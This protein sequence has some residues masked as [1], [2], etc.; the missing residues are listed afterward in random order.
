MAETAKFD[1]L[2]SVLVRNRDFALRKIEDEGI[3]IPIRVNFAEDNR[4]YNLNPLAV[5]FWELVDGRRTGTEIR[6]LLAEEYDVGIER[7]TEDLETFV[8]HLLSIQ[9]ILLGGTK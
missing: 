4:I 9:G 2:S 7:L 3:L 5:R 8:R 6:D 1:W